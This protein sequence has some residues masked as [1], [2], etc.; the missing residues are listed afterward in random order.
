M[1]LP[2]RYAIDAIQQETKDTFTWTLSSLDGQ[3]SAFLPGQFHMI[4][5]FGYGEIPISISGDPQKKLMHTIRAVG[6]I[7]SHL[8]KLS[9]GEEVG[10]RGPFGTHWPL[11]NIGEDLLIIAGGVGIAP[12]RPVVYHALQNPLQ[13]CRRTLLYGARTPSDLLYVQEMEQWKKSG[14]EVYTTVDHA[15]D[16]WNGHVGVVTALIRKALIRPKHTLTLLCGPEV[17]MQF[18]IQEL[19]RGG[20][21]EERIYLSLERNMECAIG[22]CGHCQLGP[23]FLCKDGPIFSYPKLKKW[24]YI[25]EL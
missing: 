6:P 13:Y 21:D 15:E 18:A 25:R 7:T 4:Y 3:D 11:E 2:K 17:M 20:V 8:Q 1:I 14:F 12:L 16:R 22:F 23:Y 10:I 24:M 9:I 19:L 5:D